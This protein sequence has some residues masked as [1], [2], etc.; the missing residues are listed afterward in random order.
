MKWMRV[1]KLVFP[2]QVFTTRESRH[3][4][5][6]RAKNKSREADPQ[7]APL[8]TLYSSLRPSPLVLSDLVAVHIPEPE[9]FRVIWIAV[10]ARLPGRSVRMMVSRVLLVS[11]VTGGEQKPGAS[12]ITAISIVSL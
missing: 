7:R 4:G 2:E 11:G 3:S 1:S 9:E 5:S 6:V 10:A 12:A 8:T